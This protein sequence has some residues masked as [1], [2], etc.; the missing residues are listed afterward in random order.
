MV[1]E[2]GIFEIKDYHKKSPF[3]SFLPGINGIHGIPIWCFYVN[4]G[5]GVTSFGTLDKD[6]SIMEFYP[7]HQAYQRTQTMGFRTFLKI[8]GEYA[9][10]FQQADNA[11]TMLIDSN[12]LRIEEVLEEQGI[13]VSVRYITLPE[14]KLG[15][16]VR[17]VTIENL[18]SNDKA[19]AIADGMAEI[20]PY[21]VDLENMKEMSQTAKAWMQVEQVKERK[22]L[23]RVR[24]S[25]K[26]SAQ[27]Q[28]YKGY[29]FGF[30][31]ESGSL[32]PVIV[33]KEILFGYDC[34]LKKPVE[35]TEKEIET[36]LSTEQIAKNDLPCSFFLT[37]KTLAPGKSFTLQEI[38]G[39]GEKQ[40]WLEELINKALQSGYFE[41]KFARAK[42]LVVSLTDPIETKTGHTV[43]D[44]YCRQTYLDNL[45]RGGV[46]IQ[47]GKH[48]FYTYSRKHGDIERDYNFFSM[49]PEAYSQGNGNF[50][51]VNQNR[52]CDV[53]FAPF[54]GDK[55]IKYFYNN[56][57]LNGYNPLGIEKTIY[58]LEEEKWFEMNL[59]FAD[60][61]QEQRVRRIVTEGYTPGRLYEALG[62]GQLSEEE[63]NRYFDNIL[64]Q[65][66]ERNRTAF[67]EGY[68]T[69]HWTYNLD[70]AES[71]LSV[72]PDKEEELFY[73]REYTYR[74]AEA[75][76]LPR[77]KR[78]VKT[79]KGVRQYRFLEEV[80]AAND[81]V[82]TEDG[83]KVMATLAEKIFLLCV[84][85]TAALDAYGMGI[86]MEGGKPGWY[87]ALNGLPGLCGSSMSE[88]YELL[89]NIKFLQKLVMRYQKNMIIPVELY[90][91][92]MKIQTA[93]QQF[94]VVKSQGE[95]ISYWNQVNDAKES[96]WEHTA[97]QTSGVE[98]E[99]AA[100]EVLEI[101]NVFEGIV[102][103]GIQ[104][105]DQYS[106][107]AAPTY[108]Y[109]EIEN[110][111]E[112]KE[113]IEVLSFRLHQIPDFLEGSVHAMKL[114]EEEEEKKALYRRVKQS[115]LYDKK[116]EMYKVNAS[117][118]DVTLEAGRTTVFTPGWLENESIWLHMEYKYLLELLKCGLYD[119]FISDFYK[120][121]VPFLEEEVYGR[122]LL[123][124]SSFLVSSANPNS[125]IHGKGFVAR[126]S[127][128]TAEF[129][130]MW[131]IMM[132]GENP[133]S[134]Q[135]G[136]LALA[137]RPMLP[138]YLIGSSQTICARFLGTT[139]VIYH[140]EGQ[141]SL[142]PGEYQITSCQIT[143]TNG[144]SLTTECICGKEAE[145][146][147]EGKVK[148]IEVFIRR[149][150]T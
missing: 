6:H 16:L 24:A 62:E 39:M 7:A 80:V 17:S 141:E 34:S 15:G 70:L 107:G 13:K 2:D 88:T 106:D 130:Q 79:D 110:Y 64:E 98:K 10:A 26:D 25:L 4:R 66:T 125:A 104:K 109:Y 101:L 12:E 116:L 31:V 61:E 134:M 112:K 81:E 144:E 87:D 113:G 72:F 146:V 55:N 11:S 115:D 52:R 138:A 89:R 85:K 75:K 69:D 22:P 27:V 94:E 23:F 8:D 63:Q 49:Y 74:Q 38:Y 36:L 43:F 148:C 60:D 78:Y 56:I 71:Y 41:G 44:Y 54:V 96:Y 103:R 143:K 20:V 150:T 67:L 30:A 83:K 1:R 47:L 65:S 76:I 111:C 50:R 128:S 129:L 58:Q 105:A 117:L 95:V 84:T 68:W 126:L 114:L 119:E 142:I 91:L 145:A 59:S 118:S 92:A 53:P 136:E 108:F 149:K 147:R 137:F 42:E 19:I 48:V 33:D 28:E 37:E 127:G 93:A 102:A 40:E 77:K 123:E 45:L 120:A 135:D 35:F 51:D 32:L 21:G 90:E 133:F 121:G 46:P 97:V 9:E 5:Q 132:F 14:E 73:T 140:L 100:E 29:H 86:E 131:Q 139:D 18:S 57:Q 82:R 3:A 99:L 124:N 122:S